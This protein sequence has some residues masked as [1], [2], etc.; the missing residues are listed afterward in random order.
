[1]HV[2]EDPW[3]ARQAS[4]ALGQFA[5]AAPTLHSIWDVLG[6]SG[7]GLMI[8]R[9][10]LVGFQICRGGLAYF[11]GIELLLRVSRVAGGVVRT[12]GEG[13]GRPV[14]VCRGLRAWYW[15]SSRLRQGH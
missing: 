3:W 5:G 8:G 13:S 4:V 11:Q 2:L 15:A 9:G 12:C 6:K 1:M 14:G 10:D 7:L